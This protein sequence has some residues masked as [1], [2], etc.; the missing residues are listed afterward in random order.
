MKTQSR[1]LGISRIFGR[2]TGNAEAEKSTADS[3]KVADI[4]L[5]NMQSLAAELQQSAVQGEYEY[6]QNWML[7]A[8]TLAPLLVM[9]SLAHA[10]L[11]L[12]PLA[13]STPNRLNALFS[14][15]TLG[16][17]LSVAAASLVAAILL[18]LFPTIQITAQGL[19][20]SELLGWRV[21]P[22]KQI[23][24]LRVMELHN[25]SRYVVLIPFTGRT[26]P[27]T[28]APMLRWLPALVG[29]T[30]RGGRG[31]LITSDIKNFDRLM[32]LVISYLVQSSG[33]NSNLVPLEAFV[34]EDSVMPIA[35]LLFDP[36]AEIVRMSNNPKGKAELYGVSSEDTDPP[37]A[38][39]PV[40]KRQLLIAL[41]PVFVLLSDVLS[42]SDS[43]FAWQYLAWAVLML[44]LGIAELPFV[45]MLV[46]AVGELMVGSGE[47]NRTVW[48]YLELQLPR[49]AL[50]MTG[51]ALL[52]AG[53][54]ALFTEVLWFAGIVLTT[55]LTVRFVQRLYYMPLSHTLLAALGAFIFQF[56]S[57]ALYFGVR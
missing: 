29:A 44:G 36:E 20:V 28:P 16:L 53:L 7:V 46:R 41:V 5:T 4:P 10:A 56:L 47:F 9:L 32:Q 26:K 52:A 51:G 18:N 15:T 57:L 45:G 24:V 25:R 31:V 21:I 17:A 14:W 42:R 35:Q 2:R 8:R 38:W 12:I 48:A 33:Q 13:A 54:P 50:I 40:L 39:P 30:G 23:S 27:A 19:G 34:D 43:L 49:A 37:V 11:V 6:P 3:A 55:F 22:W 1:S